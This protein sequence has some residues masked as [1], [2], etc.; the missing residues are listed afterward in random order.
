MPNKAIRMITSCLIILTLTL[1]ACTSGTEESCRINYSCNDL[2]IEVNGDPTELAVTVSG[3]SRDMIDGYTWDYS[4]IDG[5]VVSFKNVDDES[6]SID[7]SP[8]E[9]TSE[10]ELEHKASV[11]IKGDRKGKAVIFIKAPEKTAAPFTV[12]EGDP[13]TITIVDPYV[14]NPPELDA[15]GNMSVLEGQH[16]E[17]TISA[18][19]WDGDTLTFSV[20]N[21]PEGADFDQDTRTF[22]WAPEEKGDYHVR[23]EVSDGQLTDSEDITITVNP[24]EVEQYLGAIIIDHQR[25]DITQIPSQWIEQAKLNFRVWYGHTSHGSQITTGMNNLKSHYG[26]PYDFNKTGSGG[27]LSYQEVQSDLGHKGSLTWMNSTRSQLNQPD[28]DRNVVIWSWCGGVSD[29]TKEGIDTY[30]NAMNQLEID[31]PD[32][33]F[34]YMTGHLD[35]TGESG[36]LNVRNNQIRSYCI[37]NNK[38][39]FD[40]ADIESYDPDGNYFLDLN[41]NDNCDYNGGNWAQEWCAENPGSDLCWSCSCAH[42]QALNCNLKGGAFWWMMARIVGWDGL[43]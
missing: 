12:T 36:S 1:T 23:F 22:S 28:N 19:D 30:L 3:V 4:S 40:F 35:G 39:L 24:A 13:C 20:K 6:I 17:F 31:Y 37:E 41:A 43:Y 26:S 10:E 29:N 14:N 27:A 15:I 25:T 18:N 9:W 5:G 11:K 16:L 21:L 42:S 33:V 38:I 32:V 8:I 7:N 34:I 2:I